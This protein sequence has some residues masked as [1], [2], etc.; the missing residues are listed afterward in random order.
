R[1]VVEDEAAAPRQTLRDALAEAEPVLA[2]AGITH[3]AR[4]VFARAYV[5]QQA[6]AR[7]RLG[8]RPIGMLGG[9]V[10]PHEIAIEIFALPGADCAEESY[11]FALRWDGLEVYRDARLSA[12]RGCP[13]GYSVDRFY[14]S[15]QFG[16]Q[17]G[18]ALIGVYRQ[19]FEGPDLRYLAVPIPLEP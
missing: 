16:A 6:G 13:L 11:G 5:T 7:H 19:S 8:W 15:E 17:Y 12:S 10:T 3:P 14:V 9:P 4:L 1:R 2:E 18:V